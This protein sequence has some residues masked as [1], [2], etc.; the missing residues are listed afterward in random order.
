MAKPKTGKVSTGEESECIETD[1][2]AVIDDRNRYWER[3]CPVLDHISP[4]QG[5]STALRIIDDV[6]RNLQENSPDT[7]SGEILTAMSR[8]F[9]FERKYFCIF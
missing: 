5:G 9:L 2:S 1:V 7:N 3:G 6:V 4:P 8:L